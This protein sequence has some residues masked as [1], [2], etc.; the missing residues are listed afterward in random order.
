MPT[1]HTNEKH[2]DDFIHS[3]HQLTNIPLRK[4]ERYSKSN[5]VIN[6][7]EHPHVLEPTATQ[8]QKLEQLS[9][10]LRSYRI[11]SWAA[12]NDKQT[13][14]SP[15]QAGHFFT[16]YLEGMKDHEQFMVA[17]LDTNNRIIETRTISEGGLNYTF[18]HPRNVLKAALN[19]DCASLILAHNHPSGSRNPSPEDLKLTQRI[20]DV[21]SPLDIQVLDHIIIA[22][23]GYVSLA[24][25][26]SL[27]RAA[28]RP[29]NYEIFP[30]SVQEPQ[31]R[32]YQQESWNT[33]EYE[34]DWE[35]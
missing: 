23:N 11:V 28:E 8:L 2:A 4:L 16:A 31:N 34:E 24:E 17:F 13:I 25:T 9:A 18:V 15:E 7:L 30:I 21:F 22:G 10:F 1:L 35:R 14:R 19:C 3:L 33:A 12:E 27:P 5:Q 29:A 6:V 20:V 32:T 26:G